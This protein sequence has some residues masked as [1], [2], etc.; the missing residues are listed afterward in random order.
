[1]HSNI[2][3]NC[4][5]FK[6]VWY[7]I[8]ALLLSLLSHFTYKDWNLGRYYKF[9][10]PSV[11]WRGGRIQTQECLAQTPHTS[12]TLKQ[13]PF[14]LISIKFAIVFWSTFP[15]KKI[16]VWSLLGLIFFCL[17]SSFL[18]A[19]FKIILNYYDVY[20]FPI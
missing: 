13:T 17:I 20:E 11:M 18:W 10:F 19:V 16:L 7:F 1:M 4:K 2:F 12:L 15:R 6:I 8:T 3:E 14:T 5:L 9:T